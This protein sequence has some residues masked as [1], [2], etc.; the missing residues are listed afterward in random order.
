MSLQGGR[1]L[2]AY[3]AR[4]VG[5]CVICVCV[6]VCATLKVINTLLVRCRCTLNVTLMPS[7]VT[8]SKVEAPQHPSPATLVSASQADS[9]V[10]KHNRK[11]MA[12]VVPCAALPVPITHDAPTRGSSRRRW[13]YRSLVCVARG[14]GGRG[15]GLISSTFWRELQ[16]T[17]N[18]S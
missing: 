11:L 10:P 9:A 17:L 6:C 4:V 15:C 18:R 2:S 13:I 16:V 7:F 1:L 8:D 14:H 5:V 3:H 12:T